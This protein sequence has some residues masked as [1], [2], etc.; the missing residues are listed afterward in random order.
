MKR[1]V[2]QD[3]IHAINNSDIDGILNLMS[4]D[5]VFTDSQDNKLT[6][7][8]KLR[9]AWIGYFEL[10]PDYKIEINEILEKDSLVCILGYASGT[11]LNIKNE[12]NTNYWSIPAAWRAMIRNNQVL[13]WQV[14]ADNILVMEIIK[15]NCKNPAS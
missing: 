12:N 4:E 6:G 10:F 15:R 14:Y 1:K 13:A 9:Q 2:V 3:F 11:Y 8:E 5:H 7:K